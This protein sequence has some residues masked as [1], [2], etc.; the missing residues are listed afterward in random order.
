[1]GDAGVTMDPITAAGI[2]G[3]LRDAQLLCGVLHEGLSGQRPLDEALADY[4]PMRD[5]MAEPLHQFAHDMARL[6]PPPPGMLP[7]FAALAHQPDQADRY[8]GL[9]GQ[10]VMPSDFFSPEN[11]GAILSPPAARASA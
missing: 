1:M 7:V 4:G 9:F 10:T 3:A 8:F 2:T 6:Q 11:L 5:R